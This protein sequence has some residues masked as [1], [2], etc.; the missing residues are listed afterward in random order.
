M[1]NEKQNNSKSIL[2]IVIGF[3]LLSL[4]LKKRFSLDTASN[5]LWYTTMGIGVLSLLSSR[6]ESG[7]VWLWY[8]FAEGL[9]W[10]NTRILLGLI[11]FI[12]LTPI[13]LLKKLLSKKDPLKLKNKGDSTFVERN[14]TYVAKDL[15]N[16]W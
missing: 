10:I 3:S 5:Y 12:F 2:V 15:D 9:G 8:K 1:S 4:L 7:I 6:I 13:A 16:I 14:H 11:F